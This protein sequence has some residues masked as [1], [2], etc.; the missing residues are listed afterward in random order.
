[1]KN[2]KEH[3]SIIILNWNGKHLL[4]ENL[5]SVLKQSYTSYDIIIVD[6]GSRDGSIRYIKQLKKKYKKI[7][8][9]E[10]KKNLGYASGN[11]KGIEEALENKSCKYIVILNNDIKVEKNWL[12]NLIKGFNQDNIGICTSKILLYYPFQQIVLLPSTNCILNSLNINKLKYHTLFF[13]DEFTAQGNLINFPI[14]L[15]AGEIYR[16]GVPYK[17]NGKKINK[18]NIDFSGER[19]KLF[20][21]NIRKEIIKSGEIKI[22]LDGKYIIQNAGSRFLNKSKTFED[23]HI[24]EFEKELQSE[25][26]DAGCGACMAIR[27]D[28]LKRFGSFIDHYFMYNEDSELSY[29]FSRSHFYTRFINDAVC[30]HYFWGSN[31]GEVSDTQTYYGTRNRLLFIRKYFGLSTYIFFLIKTT[32]RTFIWML[33]SLIGKKNAYLFF[34]NYKKVIID[35]IRND[36]EKR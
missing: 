2:N 17:P 18:L 28:L 20:S 30:Y 3:V 6:N 25:I 9:V 33:K 12:K 34:Q 11:N 19:L 35:L 26:V 1:M 24:F 32:G 16:F 14:K 8:L 4:K 15:K 27:T 10:N 23:K 13:N 7:S 29:R 36:Y 22:E 5:E 31:N 21:C